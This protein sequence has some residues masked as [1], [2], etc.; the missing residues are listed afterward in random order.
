MDPHAEAVAIRETHEEVGLNLEAT[1]RLGSLS[2]LPILPAGGVLAPFVFYLGA[3]RPA[4][5]RNHEVDAV[6]WVPL[7]HLWDPLQATTIR[8]PYGDQHLVFP[9]IR[10]GDEVIWGLTYRILVSL[11]EV[12]GRPLPSPRAPR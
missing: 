12:L 5:R 7:E 2:H 9:G 11:A 1:E 8:W 4:A 3:E 6:F 10:W